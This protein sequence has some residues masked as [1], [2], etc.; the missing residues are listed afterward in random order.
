LYE[1]GRLEFVGTVTKV[2][3]DTSKIKI[4]PEYGEALQGLRGFSHIIVLYWFH[5]NDNEEQRRILKVKPRRHKGAPEVGVFASRSPA[6]PNPIGLTVCELL[7][8]RERTL[9]VMELD[10]A[11]GTPVIDIKPYLP[12]AD[13]VR[14]AH[15]PSWT[16]EGPKT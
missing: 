4:L 10:A 1:A 3:D 6:R 7:D 11:E 5:L 8:I 12:R 15:G 16:S 9:T 2:E 14:D 13:C